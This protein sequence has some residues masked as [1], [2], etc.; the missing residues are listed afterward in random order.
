MTEAVSAAI[1]TGGRGAGR[2]RGRTGAWMR[3]Q[4]F[5]LALM[6]PVLLFLIVT[7]FWPLVDTSRIS[8][9]DYQPTRSPDSTFVGVQNYVDLFLNDRRF[10]IITRNSFLWMLGS[11]AVQVV[12]GTAGALVLNMNLRLRGLWRGLMMVPW[13]TPV[14]VVAIIWRWM[15][16][17]GEN[18]LV[19][20]YLGQAGLLSDPLVW[21][22][23]DVWVWPVVLLA[24]TWKGTP[25]VIL[26]VLAGLQSLPGELIESARVDGAGAFK[27]F[28]YVVLP[29]LRPTLAVT[30]LIALVTVWFKFELIWALTTGGPAFATTILPIYV[31]TQ[32]FRDFNF[33][34]AG[35]VATIA[36]LTLLTVV[37]VLGLLTRLRK[38]G[39]S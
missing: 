27:R 3:G 16:D 25:F 38:E 12:V 21:L 5:W 31:F 15:F 29:H 19:N 35:A 39:S 33:G 30:T 2:V 20:Y 23:S 37:G 32:A 13:V 10:W 36:M 18:G 28:R 24:S 4:G 26:L 9:F 7:Q 22:S 8:V 17:G 11:T 1:G 34:M 6:S 14:V